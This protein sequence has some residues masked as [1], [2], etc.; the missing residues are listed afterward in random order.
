MSN[1]RLV[2]VSAGVVI[3]LIVAIVVFFSN[4]RYVEEVMWRGFQGKAKTDHYYLTEQFLTKKG[5]AVTRERSYARMG[6]ETLNDNYDTLLLTSSGRTLSALQVT[7]IVD[8]VAAGGA[9]VVGSGE[10]SY[11][12]SFAD[13][14]PTQK[15]I[16]DN[17]KLLDVTGQHNPLFQQLGIAVTVCDSDACKCPDYDS[18]EDIEKADALLDAIVDD[19]NALPKTPEEEADE[20]LRVE[21][22]RW[23]SEV[24]VG[25]QTL[26]VNQQRAPLLYITPDTPRTSTRIA[27]AKA[28]CYGDLFASFKH[29]NGHV[30]LYTASPRQF[31]SARSWWGK[32]PLFSEHHATYLDALLQMGNDHSTGGK[33]VLWYESA[34]YPSI[35][36]TLWRYGA[37]ALVVAA[38]LLL[39]W[40]WQNSRRFGPI[41]ADNPHAGLSMK[42]HLLASGRFYYAQQQQNKLIQHCYEQLDSVIA[43]R[44][45]SYKSLNKATLAAQIAEKT[46]LSPIAIADVLARRYPQTDADFTRLINLINRIQQQL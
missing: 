4:Y 38:L 36:A 14:I 7:A 30:T 26:S 19:T 23:H 31:S 13:D 8:W 35:W 25:N 21:N 37:F 15:D 33:R 40:I 10:A 43:R 34:V 45:P 2:W 9:L 27:D 5:Y 44:I 28:Y 3:V 12:L 6:E 42:R 41:I 22:A 46:D 18:Q 17:P 32:P 16:D 29:G 20:L 11:E 24:N 1:S 39:A